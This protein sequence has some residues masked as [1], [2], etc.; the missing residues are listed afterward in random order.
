MGHD[1]YRLIR[2]ESD[3]SAPCTY[4]NKNANAR[5]F[6][7]TPTYQKLNKIFCKSK[8]V[9]YKTF[10]GIFHRPQHAACAHQTS[11]LHDDGATDFN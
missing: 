1:G 7:Y 2:I 10:A 11:M 9:F 3:D 6:L 4:N 5:N 8:I